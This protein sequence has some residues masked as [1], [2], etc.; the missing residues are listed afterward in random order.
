MAPNQAWLGLAWFGWAGLG[1]AGLGWARLDFRGEGCWHHTTQ[2]HTTQHVQKG[3]R[4]RGVIMEQF[5]SM[6]CLA[7]SLLPPYWLLFYA[8]PCYTCHALAVHNCKVS[9]VS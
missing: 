8:V 3:A 2:Q 6:S 5:C 7:D 1:W 4:D 9:S